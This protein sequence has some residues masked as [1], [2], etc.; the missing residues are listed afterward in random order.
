MAT[1]TAAACLRQGLA[2]DLQPWPVTHPGRPLPQ[3][4]HPL[5]GPHLPMG[6]TQQPPAPEAEGASL[7]PRTQPLPDSPSG[8]SAKSREAIDGRNRAHRTKSG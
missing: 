6:V 7:Q 1:H 5:A 8:L 3:Q 4:Y 2:G